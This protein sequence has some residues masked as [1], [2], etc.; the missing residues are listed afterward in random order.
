MTG[1]KTLRIVYWVATLLFA[2]PMTWSAIQ[3]LIE[4]PKMMATMTHLG[5]PVYFTKIL[6]VAKVL[7]V[8]AIVVGRFRRLK[9]WA[10]A[11]FT[12]DVVSAFLSHLASGDS[13]AIA[14]VPIGFLVLLM[15]SYV[16]WRRLDGP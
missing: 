16:T 7:G 13:I 4:A 8:A 2:I 10:Y 5:Y 9:E 14:L 12:F 15:I 3:Y 1:K 11:G 6:G